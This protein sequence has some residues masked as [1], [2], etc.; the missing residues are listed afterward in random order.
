MP[1]PRAAALRVKPS[2]AECQCDHTIAMIDAAR[3]TA[4]S[5]AGTGEGAAT[6]EDVGPASSETEQSHA[7]P[8]APDSDSAPRAPGE[9]K[10]LTDAEVAGIETSA[11]RKLVERDPILA[12]GIVRLCDEW[13]DLTGFEWPGRRRRVHAAP[14]TPAE[15]AALVALRSAAAGALMYDRDR[16]RDELT[17]ALDAARPV[18][19][20]LKGGI[21]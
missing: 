6:R 21:E 8:P 7:F 12:E 11:H 17:R 10:P 1:D 9:M 2:T 15:I 13:R 3:E 14:L 19:A 18:L 5:G 16:I 20:R 4:E